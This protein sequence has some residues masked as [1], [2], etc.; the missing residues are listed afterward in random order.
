MVSASRLL[1]KFVESLLVLWALYKI[2]H[3]MSLSD[4][5]IHLSATPPENL[6][7][8]WAGYGMYKMAVDLLRG[9]DAFNSFV[10]IYDGLKL[11]HFA[12][13][14]WNAS[15]GK[16][17]IEKEPFYTS[18]GVISFY[19]RWIFKSISLLHPHFDICDHREKSANTDNGFARFKRTFLFTGSE[20]VS[21]AFVVVC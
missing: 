13:M 4:L 10:T 2:L 20:Q 15:Y 8:I 11:V 12:I 6:K 18:L 14:R 19:P 9:Q 3:L 16:T 17:A 7:S 5:I 1:L 21:L